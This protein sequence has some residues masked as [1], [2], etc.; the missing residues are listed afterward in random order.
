M[1]RCAA[2]GGWHKR[3]RRGRRKELGEEGVGREGREKKKALEPGSLGEL[4]GARRVAGSGR[5]TRRDGA[6]RP[7][8]GVGRGGGK[9]RRHVG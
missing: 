7:R 6:W 4:D 8:V 1:A 2:Q 3:R 5:P 9:A